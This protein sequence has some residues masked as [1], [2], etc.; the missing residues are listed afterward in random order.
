MRRMGGGWSPQSSHVVFEAGSWRDNRGSFISQT[1]WGKRHNGSHAESMPALHW[2]VHAGLKQAH[3]SRS[4]PEKRG[5]GGYDLHTHS[6]RE[7]GAENAVGRDS[8]DGDIFN[9]FAHHLKERS[10]GFIVS[11]QQC[12]NVPWDQLSILGDKK[13]RRKR[14]VTGAKSTCFCLFFFFSFSTVIYILFLYILSF[15]SWYTWALVPLYC[16]VSDAVQTHLHRKA[17]CISNSWATELTS[18]LTDLQGDAHADMLECVSPLPP[19]A[20]CRHILNNHWQLW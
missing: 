4:T 3:T 18:S 20:L 13:D 9:M 12:H 19:S 8:I 6:N 5:R 2:A 16:T 11:V 17:L 7:K 10:C 1:Q 14:N 15:L